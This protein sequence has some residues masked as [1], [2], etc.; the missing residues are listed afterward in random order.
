MSRMLMARGGAFL[1]V[2]VSLIFMSQLTGWVFAGP[3]FN[4]THLPPNWTGVNKSGVAKWGTH[5]FEIKVKGRAMK[6]SN[7]SIPPGSQIRNASSMLGSIQG[8]RV[9]N[10]LD[11]V[12]NR[13]VGY[14]NIHGGLGK[15]FNLSP[16]I[17]YEVFVQDDVNWTPPSLE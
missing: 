8:A 17:V 4:K 14:I 2:V 1:L 12:T 16:N 15:N 13:T 11:S 5:G 6:N 10:W 3:P 7:I 9:I